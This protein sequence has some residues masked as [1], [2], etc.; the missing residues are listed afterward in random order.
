LLAEL[1]PLTSNVHG[2]PLSRPSTDL[3]RAMPP[4]AH[5]LD[6]HGLCDWVFRR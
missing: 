2:G 4:L 5:H 3:S 6:L 1:R